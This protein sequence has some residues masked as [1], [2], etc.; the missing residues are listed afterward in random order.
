MLYLKYILL[1]LYPESKFNIDLI[2]SIFTKAYWPIYG[3]MKI[4]EDFD[5]H[6]FLNC[7]ERNDCPE[8][9]G[10]IFSYMLLMIYMVLS[11]VLLINL[12]IAMFR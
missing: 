11:N 6:H 9:S 8:E 3:T 5:K 1:S 7:D 12:L 4:L 2:R 10:V